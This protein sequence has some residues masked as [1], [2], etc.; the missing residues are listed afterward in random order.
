MNTE[1]DVFYELRLNRELAELEKMWYDVEKYT[2]MPD[3]KLCLSLC[4][5]SI[6]VDNTDDGLKWISSQ[7]Q[8]IESTLYKEDK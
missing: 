6:T 7:Y 2:M 3:D 5:K 8:E 1:L 4:D